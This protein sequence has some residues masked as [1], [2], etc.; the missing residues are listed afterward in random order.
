MRLSLR[1]LTVFDALARLGTLGRAGAE[2]GMSQSAASMALSDL[3]RHLGGQLF[4]RQGK[5]LRLNEAGRALHPKVRAI[6]LQVHAIEAGPE[7]RPLAGR[8]QIAATPAA[9]DC[10][11]P[12]FC[13]EF[14]RQHPEVRISLRVSAAM[15]VLDAV[16]RMSV[17]LGII[18]TLTARPELTITSWRSE[19]LVIFCAANH[20]LAG[21]KLDGIVALR[22]YDWV[23]EEGSDRV[24]FT[25]GPLAELG[26]I[27]IGF[28]S[29]SLAAI[30]LA[31]ERGTGLGCLPL[32]AIEHEVARG[33]FAILQ[34]PGLELNRAY[35]I[36]RRRDV[37]GGA[38][39]DAFFRSL[40]GDGES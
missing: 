15:E 8:L 12:E 38:L 7:S 9:A 39:L 31:V 14:M 34:V 37:A 40:I 29:G 24:P 32:A 23:L 21:R 30:R 6:L 26:A 22:G 36:I 18:G 25:S 19:N 4:D 3:E 20:P 13:A 17:D 28:E 33:S 1:Q 11:L 5:R 10:L 2:I 16:S 35:G 27:R